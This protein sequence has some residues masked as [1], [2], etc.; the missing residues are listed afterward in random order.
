MS[1]KDIKTQQ[2]GDVNLTE[3]DDFFDQTIRCVDCKKDF[4]WAIGEQIF[5]RDKG[6]L[7]PP[8]RCRYEFL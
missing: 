7:N 8:K 4:I 1:D 2:L 3:K 5:F 6:L